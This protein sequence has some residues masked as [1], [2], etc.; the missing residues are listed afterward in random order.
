MG[1]GKTLPM[2]PYGAE[3]FKSRKLYQEFLTRPLC[4]NY[5]DIQLV[6][7]HVA[8]RNLL[9][10]PENFSSHISQYVIDIIVSQQSRQT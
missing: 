9:K 10:T 6:H 5:T 7:A 4:A 1:W 3:F 2:L 8:L